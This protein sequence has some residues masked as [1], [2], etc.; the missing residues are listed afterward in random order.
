MATQDN[1]DTTRRCHLVRPIR[2]RSGKVRF[3][4]TP[5]IVKELDNLGRRMFLVRFEDG[6]TTFLFPHEVTTAGQSPVDCC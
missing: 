1:C 2:D 3:R 5:E 6:S 4:E